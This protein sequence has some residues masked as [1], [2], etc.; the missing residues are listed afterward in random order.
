MAGLIGTL[1]FGPM[2]M[3]M[4]SW[5][6]KLMVGLLPDNGSSTY[7]NKRRS[8]SLL[9]GNTFVEVLTI[10]IVIVILTSIITADY[11]KI[12][13]AAERSSVDW[14]LSIVK[15][16]LQRAIMD[17]TLTAINATNAF[18]IITTV[19]SPL[20]HEPYMRPAPNVQVQVDPVAGWP[21][22][23]IV[24]NPG[25]H[26]VTVGPTLP[27]VAVNATVDANS[28]SAGSSGS[29]GAAGAGGTSGSSSGS[30]GSSGG[31]S[32]SAG[33]SG[34]VVSGSAGSG[35]S[36]SGGTAGTGTS[37]SAG[38][39]GAGGSV[40]PPVIVLAD[41]QI[42]VS[43]PSSVVAFSPYTY[44]VTVMNTGP[45][46][47]T[48]VVLIDVLPP[49]VQVRNSSGAVVDNRAVLELASLA[50]GATQTM[51]IS[52]TAPADGLLTN[53]ASVTSAEMDPSM[54]DNSSVLRTTVTQLA[55]LS[56]NVTA[57]STVNSLDGYS[58]IL[59]ITNAG[60]SASVV[61]VTNS[62]PAGVTL[63]SVP[64]GSLLGNQWVIPGVHLA[65]GS[66]MS[67]LLGVTAPISGDLDDVVTLQSSVPTASD[68]VLSTSV[69]THV[70]PQADLAVGV[71]AP[72]SVDAATGYIFTMAVTNLGPASVTNLS[73]AG[74]I[75]G[76]FASASDGGAAVGNVVT[77]PAVSLAAGASLTRTVQLTAA[78]VGDM[79]NSV[80]VSSEVTDPV[81]SNNSASV[82]SSVIPLADLSLALS[83]PSSVLAATTYTE[84]LIVSNAGPSD[85]S[86]VTIS[87]AWPA[88]ASFVDGS[89]GAT[90][91]GSTLYVPVGLTAG[92]T[93]TFSISLTA[94]P[95][96]TLETLATVASTVLD[97]VLQNNSAGLSIAVRPVADVGVSISAA[98]SALAGST[99]FY[100]IQVTNAGPSTASSVV[101]TDAVPAGLLTS[102]NLEQLPTFDLLAGA[103]TNFQV[104]LVVPGIGVLTNTV[105]G[106]SATLDFNTADKV[107]SCATTV[108]PVA[109]LT[110]LLQ[111][112][113]SVLAGASYSY[114]LTLTNAGPSPALVQV[115]D[116]LPAGVG[117]V[118]A[119]TATVAGGVI[120]FPP[121]IVAAGSSVSYL[122]TASAPGAGSLV[123]SASVLSSFACNTATSTTTVIPVADIVTA[124]SGAQNGLDG[125]LSE[126][127]VTAYNA[128]PSEA[129]VVVTN[130]VG[131]GLR[132]L[133]VT[134]QG[135]VTGQTVTFPGILLSAGA[136]A[137]YA[138][139]AQASSPGNVTVLAGA[140]GDVLDPNLSNNVA[141]STTLILPVVDLAVMVAAPATVAAGSTLT[142]TILAANAGMSEADGLVVT[143]T[144]PA[145]VTYVSSSP[146]GVFANGS[147]VF[148]A[149]TLASGESTVYYVTVLA[150]ASGTLTDVVNASSATDAAWPYSTTTQVI[151]VADLSV[152]LVAPSTGLAGS[153][154]SYSLLVSNAGPSTA[155]SVTVSNY[156]AGVTFG[157]GSGGTVYGNAVV[158]TRASLAAGGSI[159]LPVS[160]TPLAGGTLANV[161]TVSS[162]TADPSGG[163]NLA[164]A[165]ILVATKADLMLAMSAPTTV[166]A[167]GAYTVSLVV[168]NAGY[169]S[170]VTPALTVTLPSGVTVV[171]A[172]G[173]TQS[174]GTL[175][176]SLGTLSA[177][178]ATNFNV[179]LTAP[180]SGSLTAS[181]SVSSLTV[182]PNNSNNLSTVTT[183]VNQLA[184]LAVYVS[185]PVSLLAGSSYGYSLTVSNVGPGTATS[186][187]LTNVLPTG[188]TCQSYVGGTL[189]GSTV[190]YA[191][192][193]LLAGASQTVS[194][195]CTA[196]ATGP[197]TDVASVGSAVADPVLANNS[198][199]VATGVG[200][201]GSSTAGVVTYNAPSLSGGVINGSI[202]QLTGQGVIFNSGT[203]IN[204]DLL[205][206]G[207]PTIITN[208]SP[209]N[210]Q[211]M[212]SGGGAATPTGYNIMLNGGI[213]VRHIVSRTTPVTMPTVASVPSPTGT[214]SINLNSPSD[215]IGSFTTLLSINA[216]S[217]V[218]NVTV[219][220]GTYGTFSMGSGSGLVLGVAGST[221]PVV[222]NFQNL[223]INSGCWVSLVG[224]VI[225]NVANSVNANCNW[226]VNGC[227]S[228][229]TVQLPSGGFTLNSGVTIY[230]SI[231]APNGTVIVNGSSYIVGSSISQSFI[232]NSGAT[233]TAGADVGV[234]V[235]GAG[236][237]QVG[238]PYTYAVT[239]T[240]YGPA[241]ASTVTVTNFIPTGM[242][243]VSSSGGVLTSNVLVF[244]A[245]TLAANAGAAYTVTVLATTAGTQTNNISVGSATPDSNMANNTTKL[246]SV[247][248]P[249]ADMQ[250][251]CS[252]ASSS[253]AGTTYAYTVAATNLGLS[254]ATATITVP[255]PGNSTYVSN[256]LRLLVTNNALTLSAVLAA[257]AGTNYSVS[258]IAGASG[259]FLPSA[260]VASS[261]TDPTMANNTNSIA[262]SIIPLADLG[263][264]IS[265]PSTIS[266]GSAYTYLLTVTNAGP[267]AATGVV[268]TDTLPSGVGFLSVSNGSL[269]GQVVTCS[270]GTLASGSNVVVGINV[271][272][273]IVTGNLVDIASVASTSSDPNL[274]NNQ[275]TN[276]L[277]VLPPATADLGISLSG[278]TQIN[279]GV[280]HQLQITITNIGPNTALGVTAVVTLP[281]NLVY[282]SA[283]S[284]CVLSNSSVVYSNPAVLL[285][286][287]SFTFTVNS[288]AGLG[289]GNIVASCVSQVQ[290]PVLRNNAASMS[291]AVVTAADL[292]VT[293]WA[294]T[295]ATMNSNYTYTVTVVNQ[296]P[297]MATDVMLADVLHGVSLVSAGNGT[298]NGRGLV[299]WNLGNL[300][301]QQQ[302]TEFLTVVCTNG[303]A[304]VTNVVSVTSTTPDTNADNNV[305]AAVTMTSWPAQDIYP[306]AIPYS[307]ISNAVSGYVINQLNEQSSFVW[308]SWSGN[309]STVT[310]V[311][312]LT[313]PTNPP[314][315]AGEWISGVPQTTNGA[316]SQA[317][318]QLLGKV[319]VVPVW[320]QAQGS[321]STT[322]YQVVAFAQI[323]VLAYNLQQS[324]IQAVFL[325]LVNY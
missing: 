114:T 71:Q 212:T 103:S 235:V 119:P 52:V 6:K 134:G 26:P 35:T 322:L 19:P 258:V 97:P 271:T 5:A 273:P 283:S 133:S 9:R 225:I 309:P 106:G 13:L 32:G 53:L 33:S 21:N 251:T 25:G 293:L 270:L 118:S 143:D 245:Q 51:T 305:S 186:V 81:S 176:Y 215:P 246:I 216:N 90:I 288:L 105:S 126:Y 192:G 232:L 36:G 198:V 128:G 238:N 187:M 233:V 142:Y 129:N 190:T 157:S 61:G 111:A 165:N 24:Y 60:P 104:S 223:N 167:A 279:T 121:T 298:A 130:L 83:A 41:L 136:T 45:S 179:T 64:A 39:G 80:V 177:L 42:Q 55:M 96:G 151:P 237:V 211:G 120:S 274:G 231:I 4:S 191:L 199:T 170:S 181:G 115:V 2:L 12:R 203:V 315:S 287:S 316:V 218:G 117:L 160:A 254:T 261:V 295:V 138:I 166:T 275:V 325:N 185:A 86:S 313:M 173:A 196:P 321:G 110:L 306:I 241:A 214:R 200:A 266:A 301:A 195:T 312:S 78:T 239:V 89:D 269:A 145:G 38:A 213:T 221:S 144:L 286:G 294:P 48:D 93:R 282:T 299:T 227:S 193:T 265:A 77:F 74:T 27:V 248:A 149:S 296:G 243:Y 56:V 123:D 59:N 34:T 18:K 209:V 257:G 7:C 50:V 153:A 100:T 140:N 162:A 63:V 122:V 66:S 182:D 303:G 147:V 98:T 40:T 178:T 58:Y 139:N 92:S 253:I 3:Y 47:A 263:V 116:T 249:S 314:V 324:G 228:W 280:A 277:F 109:N 62:L 127:I 31:V 180:A 49:Q 79:V 242:T 44:T 210:F 236:S 73:V 148:P 43:G 135:T 156:L 141:S 146:S 276:N 310:L 302:V 183:T 154:L 319:I 304:V 323:Q 137:T 260:T 54:I 267:S 65:A 131:S 102:A 75:A 22:Y 23:M 244:P 94:P 262:V 29:G 125:Q 307:S 247:V 197:L 112:P 252:G 292:S 268:L 300:A 194:L 219:P 20:T 175:T 229:L 291:V 16:A 289:V 290:D 208:G 8:S 101:I 30:A 168:S 150:P 99:L 318:N 222:Y 234:N 113:D 91:A 152:A 284:G 278:V 46:P 124:I 17:G 256:S 264:T 82:S 226:G 155:S 87:N 28:G 285:P 189:T 320:N 11:G 163:N 159:L 224:P 10:V 171:S 272:A 220:P 76:G 188:V 230:G 259:S 1:T 184:D 297:G 206:P 201:V 67:Y 240:N 172:P 158:W 107:A 70:I 14:Q 72:N 311:N 169:S 85:V 95:T 174:S 202:Q 68:S 308:L 15:D 69:W 317:L 161:A 255:L 108:I 37:G 132:I 57:P 164:T 281:T 250:V 207:I 205:V 88:G 84:L 204:G 217:G